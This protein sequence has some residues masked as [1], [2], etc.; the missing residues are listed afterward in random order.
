MSFKPSPPAA[1]TAPTASPSTESNTIFMNNDTPTIL[2]LHPNFPDFPSH[3]RSTINSKTIWS[4]NSSHEYSS[5]N[6]CHRPRPS[7]TKSSPSLTPPP[8]HDSQP[9]IPTIHT[10]AAPPSENES[11]NPSS[12]TATAYEDGFD[13]GVETARDHNASYAIAYDDDYGYDDGGYDND[14]YDEYDANGN[15]A[16]YDYEPDIDPEPP[17][18]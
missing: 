2:N 18:D 6:E 11:D 9:I 13:A 4:N 1:S 3:L 17:P 10:I 14:H 8:S 16:S 12:P 7:V 15:D 5:D